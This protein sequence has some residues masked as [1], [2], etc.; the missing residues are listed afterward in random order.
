MPKERIDTIL[1]ENLPPLLTEPM[2]YAIGGGWRALA[3]VH[4]AMNEKPISVVHGYEIAASG[5]ADTGQE[6]RTD[7]ARPGRG[8]A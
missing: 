3:R 2:L 8:I 6:D 1:Q 5:G 4:I 7:V